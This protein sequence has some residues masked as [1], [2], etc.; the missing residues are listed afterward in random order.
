MLPEHLESAL[1]QMPA[2]LSLH[3]REGR[4]L[5]SSSW[6][7]G[8]DRQRERIQSS[9]GDEVIVPEDRPVWRAAVHAAAYRR[10]VARYRVRLQ[11]PEAGVVTIAGRAAPVVVD[12]VVRYVVVLCH[13]VPAGG[14]D[15]E[16]EC[17]GVGVT[18]RAA[19]PPA[20][21]RQELPARPAG[22]PAQARWLSPLGERIVACLRGRNWTRAEDVA[23]MLD[24][25]L[26]GD[27]RAILR[28][29]TERGILES[30]PGKGYRLVVEIVS[31]STMET[32]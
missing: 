6:A 5:W 24:E 21:T 14:G 17:P 26:T 22:V 13:E 3:D 8:L 20:V 10:E 11:T 7:Y 30:S 12:N 28:G 2:F 1:A 23:R 19:E 4:I 29:L 15:C 27:L 32:E 9:N 31:A 25:S 18:R 16:R